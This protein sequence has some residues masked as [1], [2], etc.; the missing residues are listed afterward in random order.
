M[1]T[2]RRPP[3]ALVE[4]E[5][6]MR[7]TLVSAPTNTHSHQRRLAFS[8]T[9]SKTFQ[10]VSSMCRWAAAAPALADR[11]VRGGRP[12]GERLEG[13]D[14]R[15]RGDLEALARERRDDAP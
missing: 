3:S 2:P 11:G 6:S 5:G 10:P 7:K 13:A 9:A 8:T 14:E 4:R 12:R 1:S 15:A